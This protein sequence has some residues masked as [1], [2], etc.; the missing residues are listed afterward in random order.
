M[1]AAVRQ[2]V[3]RV[4]IMRSPFAWLPYSQQ[5]ELLR[6]AVE[7]DVLHQSPQVARIVSM[8]WA[9]CRKRM[10]DVSTLPSGKALSRWRRVLWTILGYTHGSVTL[11]VE[12]K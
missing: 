9:P 12:M 1:K 10:L 4:I 8:S 11:L 2:T 3:S 5:R 6:I 7:H